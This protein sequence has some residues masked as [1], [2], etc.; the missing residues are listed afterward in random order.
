MMMNQSVV[1]VSGSL[2]RFRRGF[3]DR[4]VELGYRP[5]SVLRRLVVVAQFSRWLATE[6]VEPEELSACGMD[7]F[8][9][10]VASTSRYRRRTARRAL[11]DLLGYL[12]ELGVVRA[13][14]AP[15]LDDPNEVLLRQFADHLVHERGVARHTTTVRDYQRIARLF[16]AETVGP[17][18]AG[19]AG[20]ATGDVSGFVLAR[21]RGRSPRWARLLV[22]ALRALL[23]FVYLEGHTPS[24]LSGA[25][26]NVA[27]WRG[28]SL[29]RAIAPE[30]VRRLLAACDRRTGA[31]RRDFAVLVL[32]ARL[33]LR[34]G[35]VAAL[36]L[37]DVDWRA[38]EILIRGKA[39]R[40]EK[41]PLPPDV[42]A[43]LAGYLQRGRPR[44]HEASLF[45]QVRAPYAPL[46]PPAVR[47]IVARA[48]HRAGLPGVAAHRLRHSV[49]TGML[50][51]G[52]SLS[53]IAAV[54]R[55]RNLATTA[56]YAKVDHATLRGVA[57]PWPAGAR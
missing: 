18:G 44:R 15:V 55:H 12:V 41:L 22:T 6:G 19:L 5:S 36:G 8:V 3:E 53:E 39:D 34:S 20:I 30:Q 54:L 16:L 13:G 57:R 48:A 50:R 7:A 40:Q 31:G 23:R 35:E 11:R 42:G 4:L 32:L 28:A 2:Q 14:E 24:D 21:C 43:A 56:I 27:G 37:A 49:A 10:Q 1:V 26:P 9:A 52:A 38:G 46:R 17:D 51:E 25:V 45:L 29:P 33:G 47:A